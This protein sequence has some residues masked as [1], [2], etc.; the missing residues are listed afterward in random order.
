MP[1]A[2]EQPRY[3]SRGSEMSK[4]CCW[5]VKNLSAEMQIS[6]HQALAQARNSVDPEPITLVT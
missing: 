1:A 6:A 4:F 2:I 3:Q 5:F